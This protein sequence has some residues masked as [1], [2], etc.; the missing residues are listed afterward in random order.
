VPD[1]APFDLLCH[2]AFSH[3]SL[4]KN[5]ERVTHTSLPAVAKRR[6]AQGKRGTSAALG[7]APHN[8]PPSPIRW[9][10]GRGEGPHNTSATCTTPPIQPQLCPSRCCPSA[11]KAR[12]HLGRV[13]F[14]KRRERLP[15][16]LGERAGVRASVQSILPVPL[17]RRKLS[18]MPNPAPIPPLPAFRPISAF[19]FV[20][21]PKDALPANGVQP[22]Q[23]SKRGTSAALGYAPTIAPPLSHPMGEGQG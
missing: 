6:R 8:G 12:Q 18:S 13:G 14:H 9:E 16:S 10:R 21:S 15:L 3:L 5:P 20:L 1:A 19:C 23:P 11:Q 4:P 22:N 2:L 17:R 7:Y